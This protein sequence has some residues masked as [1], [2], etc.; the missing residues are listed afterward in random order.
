[1]ATYESLEQGLDELRASITRRLERDAETIR[2]LTAAAR[3]IIEY[4]DAT[5]MSAAEAGRRWEALRAALAKAE[6]AK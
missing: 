6:S 1:M 3:G 4:A 2:E 5:A